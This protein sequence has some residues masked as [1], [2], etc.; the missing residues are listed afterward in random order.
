MEAMDKKD[1]LLL[2]AK[3]EQAALWAMLDGLI[4]AAPRHA[5]ALWVQQV[6]QLCDE[7]SEELTPHETTS[8]AQ[9]TAAARLRTFRRCAERAQTKLQAPPA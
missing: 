6:H 3:E 1:A 8:E 7:L 4:T 2:I 9:M 5:L